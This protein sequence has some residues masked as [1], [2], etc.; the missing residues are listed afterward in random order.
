MHFLKNYILKCT[1]RLHIWIG[2]PEQ[3]LFLAGTKN[4]TASCAVNSLFAASGLILNV[5]GVEKDGHSG[6]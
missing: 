3:K 5:L 6:N 4:R 1:A 2:L